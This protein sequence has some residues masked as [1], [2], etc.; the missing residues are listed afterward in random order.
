MII[1]RLANR[2]V[3]IKNCVHEYDSHGVLQAIKDTEYEHKKIDINC[4]CTPNH[5]ILN[6]QALYNTDV[7]M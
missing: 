3:K 6:G 1:G 4:V 2:H 5:Y 7:L